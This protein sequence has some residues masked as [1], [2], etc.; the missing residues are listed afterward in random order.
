MS[1][2][3]NSLKQ[4]FSKEYRLLK[5]AHF[6]HVFNEAVPSVSPQLT[7]L[8]RKSDSNNPRLGIT[9]PKKRV[10]KAC[11]R[12]RVKRIIRESFRVKKQQ[13]PEIDIVVIG[14]SGLS[15]LNNSEISNLLEKLWKKLIKRCATA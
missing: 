4:G 6:E 8:A 11:D 9:I 15:E 10:K 1:S 2:L 7:I 3:G 5:P 12:N 13:L 14:K